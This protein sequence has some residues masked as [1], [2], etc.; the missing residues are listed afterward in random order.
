LLKRLK[1]VVAGLPILGPRLKRRYWDY[2]AR[3]RDGAVTVPSELERSVEPDPDFLRTLG[4]RFL[5][6]PQPAP[7]VH[8][9]KPPPTWPD[10][11]LFFVTVCTENHVP[12]TR[13]LLESI[14]RHHGAAPVVVAVVD[15]DDRDAVSIEGAIVLTGR[16]LIGTDFDY[17]AL[18]LTAAELCCA[19]KPAAIEYLLR[20]SGARSS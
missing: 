8:V 10:N 20:H 15:A 17:L 14:R 19:A 4:Y 2:L 1:R 7:S 11:E 12:F 6:P 16:E 5:P 18:K 9:P 3:Q 13:S